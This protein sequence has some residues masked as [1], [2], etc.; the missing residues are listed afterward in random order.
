MMDVLVVGG[1]IVGLSVGAALSRRGATV[2]VVESEQLGWGCSAAS[3][4]VIYPVNPQIYPAEVFDFSIRAAREYPGWI[5]ELSEAVGFPVGWIK[6]GLLQIVSESRQVAELRRLASRYSALA[7]DVDLV[8]AADV[9]VMDPSL[10]GENLSG[11]YFP[12]AAH[13]YVRELLEALAVVIRLQG[14]L[15]HEGVSVHDLRVER[16]AAVGAVTS[17]GQVDCGSV[18]LCTGTRSGILAGEA[19]SMRFPIQAVRGQVAVLR[20]AM[21]KSLLPLVYAD[22]MDLIRRPDGTVLVGST[23]EEGEEECIATAG[24]METL[25]ST[26]CAYVPSLR[27]HEFVKAW[28]G[29]RPSTKDG[30]PIVGAHPEIEDLYVMNGFNRNGVY[31]GPLAANIFAEE[32]LGGPPSSELMTFR[33]DR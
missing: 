7:V 29:L 26:A 31:F 21:R 19:I 30:L 23:F 33:L 18:V 27:T 2:A 17:A 5:A 10:S 9:R 8:S 22:D 28:T 1:G 4:G 32:I 24:G 16:G 20:G 6:P 14:G 25:L 3:L 15:I 12:E 11:L 13:V